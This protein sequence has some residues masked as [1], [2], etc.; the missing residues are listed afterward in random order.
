MTRLP[1]RHLLKPWVSLAL[2]GSC[3]LG[4]AGSPDEPLALRSLA[5][6]RPSSLTR[7]MGMSSLSVCDDFT[8][9][10]DDS[11]DVFA[12]STAVRSR[13]PSVV[14]DEGPSPPFFFSWSSQN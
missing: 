11:D 9:A 4:M 5:R 13:G 14:Y 1:A 12:P 2:T 7:W 6:S 10:R 8:D 3:R